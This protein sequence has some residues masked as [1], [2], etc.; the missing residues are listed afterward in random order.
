MRRRRVGK[1][2]E[3]VEG[4]EGEELVGER[5]LLVR[6]NLGPAHGQGD[7]WVGEGEAGSAGEGELRIR[8]RI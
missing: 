7:E 3:L 5:R 4:G 1:G 6:T 8:I 2:E